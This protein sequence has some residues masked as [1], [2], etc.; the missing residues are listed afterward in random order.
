MSSE[1]VFSSLYYPKRISLFPSIQTD[2]KGSLIIILIFS[3]FM[4]S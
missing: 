2:L 1:L 4:V 3:T